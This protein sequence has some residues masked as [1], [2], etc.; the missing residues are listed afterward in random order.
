MTW[1]TTCGASVRLRRPPRLR[2]SRGSSRRGPSPRPPLR[3]SVPV[4][5]PPLA[6]PSPE[7]AASAS[8]VPV[9]PAPE[10]GCHSRGCGRTSHRG[11]CIRVRPSTSPN[12]APRARARIRCKARSGTR[13][14]GS[15]PDI[16]RTPRRTP[17]ICAAWPCGS[18]DRKSSHATPSRPWSGA[19]RCMP[20]DSPGSRTP[21]RWPRSTV[22]C[23][24]PKG[25]PRS[26][27]RPTGPWPWTAPPRRRIS[28]S[29]RWR[30]S[31]AG[32]SLAPGS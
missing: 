11:P 21:T 14:S 30:C 28:P 29:A 18:P 24:R 5:P 22:T 12:D 31:G 2:R 15:P 32:T 8:G 23:R 9:A 25:G 1:P 20:R 7:S 27:R 19:I 10:T 13:R 16:A 6:A 3:P 4:A 26:K 17:R